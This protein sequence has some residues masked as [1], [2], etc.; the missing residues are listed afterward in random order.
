MPFDIDRLNVGGAMN[1]QTGKFTAPRTGKYF[2]SFS[3]LVAFPAILSSTSQLFF[4]IQLLKNGGVIGL[5]FAD[6]I[7]A[8]NKYEISSLQSTLDLQNGDQIWLQIDEMSPGAFLFGSAYTHFNG[9]FMEEEISQ[10]LNV[11]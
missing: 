10:S 5:S 8:G 9:F 3:G 2:F 7:G 1:L 6:E 11:L 4:R